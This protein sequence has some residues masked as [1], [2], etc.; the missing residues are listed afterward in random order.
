MQSSIPN[1]SSIPVA[2]WCSQWAVPHSHFLSTPPP[3][4]RWGA[5]TPSHAAR[6]HP[7]PLTWSSSHQHLYNGVWHV[8]TFNCETG[9]FELH[10]FQPVQTGDVWLSLHLMSKH[11][12]AAC[13][14]RV[15]FV[16]FH[17]CFTFKW[18]RVTGAWEVHVFIAEV[19]G[20]VTAWLP[21]TC[22]TFGSILCFS[23]LSISSLMKGLF[24]HKK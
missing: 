8:K 14:C 20:S 10:H 7:L 23:A 9:S 24:K 19:D 6:P 21:I 16:A 4:P 15:L 12:R 18:I 3:P 11:R 2:G 5:Q 13:W 17:L 22:L 1:G